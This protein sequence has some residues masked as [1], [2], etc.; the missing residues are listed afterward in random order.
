M[1]FEDIVAGFVL[2]GYVGHFQSNHLHSPI[3]EEI[4]PF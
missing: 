1:Y 4:K 3:Y 2:L